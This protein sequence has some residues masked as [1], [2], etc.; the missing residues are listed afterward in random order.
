MSIRINLYYPKE[1]ELAQ[2]P[3]NDRA[4]H[5]KR[6]IDFALHFEK[7]FKEMKDLVVKQSKQ[8]DLLME[9]ISNVDIIERGDK[10]EHTNKKEIPN[11]YDSLINDVLTIE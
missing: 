4:A 11:K 3:V 7:E 2:I 8:I 6:L 9:I 10:T 1:H 5:V